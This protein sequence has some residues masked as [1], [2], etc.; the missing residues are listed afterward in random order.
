MMQAKGVKME[1]KFITQAYNSYFEGKH[2]SASGGL[3]TSD[4]TPLFPGDDAL[5]ILGG[6]PIGMDYM[7]RRFGFP[8]HG[9]DSDKE[10]AA[11][12]LTTPMDDIFLRVSLKPWY[13]FGFCVPKTVT[14]ME[15]EIHK[16]EYL[17]EDATELIKNRDEKI[18]S[19]RKALRVSIADLLRP[20]L[21]DDGYCFNVMGVCDYD[22][23][24]LV[25]KRELAY[26]GLY[27]VAKIYENKSSFDVF[28]KM[29]YLI[30]ESSNGDIV[31]GMNNVIKYMEENNE[32]SV[33]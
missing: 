19:I 6:T 24:A 21:L 23:E 16:K 2:I 29:M 9:C 15:Y 30:K 1:N 13:S 26:A 18:E 8:F 12:Y 10:I 17:Q 33:K 25:E 5:E 31:S 4:G 14:D 20:V 7:F 32:Q 3:M 11:Y 28:H 27:N 22:E